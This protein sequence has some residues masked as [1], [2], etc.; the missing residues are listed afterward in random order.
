MSSYWVTRDFKLCKICRLTWQTVIFKY[1]ITYGYNCHRWWEPTI[2]YI[3][4]WSK[5]SIL[6]TSW[7]NFAVE[8][9]DKSSADIIKATYFGGGTHSCLQ[10]MLSTWYDSTVDRSWQMIVDALNEMK[11]IRVVESIKE[12]CKA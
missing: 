3:N 6:R 1:S 11:Q 12:C 5:D 10:D 2:K 7:Y 8:L 4:R 9:V